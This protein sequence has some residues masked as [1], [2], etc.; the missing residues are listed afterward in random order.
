MSE[1]KRGVGRPPTHVDKAG[2]K[3][4][5]APIS[6]NIPI[7]MI[8][9][10]AEQKQQNKGFNVSRYIVDLIQKSMDEGMCPNCY[11]TNLQERTIGLSCEDCTAKRMQSE[12]G[13]FNKNLVHYISFYNCDNCNTPLDLWN[14]VQYFESTPT[15]AGTRGCQVCEREF[16][17]EDSRKTLREIGVPEEVIE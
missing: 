6:I 9:W 17:L 16:K 8:D 10:I 2:K 13:V 15:T 3:I 4:L 12:G 14:T 1:N 7:R 5:T 11:G